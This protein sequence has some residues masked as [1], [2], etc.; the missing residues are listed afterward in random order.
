MFPEDIHF[1]ALCKHINL[2]NSK[3]ADIGCGTGWL[4]RK[5]R[6]AGADVTGIECSQ[7]QLQSARKQD[8]ENSRFYLEG[9]GEALPLEDESQD[10]LIFSQSLHHVPVDVM[11]KALEEAGRVLKADGKLY[12]LEPV[13]KGPMY[14]VE[15]LID[16]EAEIRNC[17]QKALAAI[18][19]FILVH[20]ENYDTPYFYPNVD[21][22]IKDM[23]DVDPVRKSR[24]DTYRKELEVRFEQF[25][26]P[27][28][29]GR[30]F[31]QPNKVKILRKS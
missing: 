9:V 22:L 17:A 14:E 27:E 8:P 10:V 2:I 12:V 13:P 24:A 19:G 29:Q 5:M 3:V 21:E 1:E 15:N 18:S 7:S 20:E 26:M 28:G 31:T 23:S 16:D 30:S 6:S 4:C 11:P 25:G